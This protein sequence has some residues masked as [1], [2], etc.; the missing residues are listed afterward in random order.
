MPCGGGHDGGP[1][2]LF[3]HI[4]RFEPRRGTNGIRH[5]PAF[6]L[7]HVGDDHL[8]AFAREDSRRGRPHT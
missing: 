8:G 3:G 4:K 1:A 6:V 2:L 5:L 7:Q